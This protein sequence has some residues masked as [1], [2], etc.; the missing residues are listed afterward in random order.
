MVGVRISNCISYE[1]EVLAAGASCDLSYLVS[2]E[3]MTASLGRS[4]EKSFSLRVT[5]IFRRDEGQWK[6]AHRHGDPY[7]ATAAS[8]VAAHRQRAPA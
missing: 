8:A 1:R 7:D 6:P 4:D 2:L 3:H 5:T